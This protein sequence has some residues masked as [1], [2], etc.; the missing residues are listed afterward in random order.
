M[1]LEQRITDLENDL[2]EAETAANDWR[3]EKYRLEGIIATQAAQIDLLQQ[4]VHA[5]ENPPIEPAPEDLSA[6]EESSNE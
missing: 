2:Q 4:T 6:P 1:D 5:L 3:N